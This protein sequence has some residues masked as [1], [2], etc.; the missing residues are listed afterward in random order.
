MHSRRIASAFLAAAL[1]VLTA[2]ARADDRAAAQQLFQ[3]GKELMRAGSFAEACPKFEA[4]EKFSATPGVRLNLAECWV[5]LGRTASAWG[6][7]DE[8][9]LMAERG[10]D[11]AAAAVAS[12]GKAALEP[13]LVYLTVAVGDPARVPGLEVHRDGEEGRGVSPSRST[14]ARTTYRQRPRAVRA[15]R[16]PR[17][18]RPTRPWPSRRSSPKRLPLRAVRTRARRSAR[19]RGRLR[20]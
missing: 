6:K 9:L 7:Y 11:K 20:S 19:R 1:A 13:Q 10:G 15:G 17:R 4:A 8:A 14:R 12:A 3:Q 18:S 2:P 5:K 16:R